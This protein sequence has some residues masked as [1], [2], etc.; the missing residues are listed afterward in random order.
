MTVVMYIEKIYLFFLFLFEKR[1]YSLVIVGILGVNSSLK[2]IYTI[3]LLL[4]LFT[5]SCYC[6]KVENLPRSEISESFAQ[7]VCSTAFLYA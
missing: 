5:S 6:F 7:L 2:N 1:G 3:Y 4:I